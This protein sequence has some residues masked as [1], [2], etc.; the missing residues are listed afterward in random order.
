LAVERAV[1]V[2]PR[3]SGNVSLRVLPFGLLAVASGLRR[4]GFAVRV[5]DLNV[6]P[7]PRLH[8]ALREAP[9]AF[10]GFSV[11]T[12]PMIQQVLALSAAIRRAHPG[13]PLVWGGPHPTIM[14]D[15]TARHPLVDVVCRGEGERTAVLLARA[16]AGGGPLEDVRGLTFKRGGEVVSTPPP[17][18]IPPGEVDREV[19]LDLASVDLAPYVFMNKGKRTAVFITSRGCPY[20]C[21][22][23]WNLMFHGRRYTAW[24]PGKVESE[25]QPLLDAGVEK[26]L[27]FDSFV[28]PVSR[29]RAVGEI[30]RGRGIEWAIEDGCRVDYHGSEE[31]FRTLA[32]TGCTH[33]AFG[34]ESGSQ[35][36]LDLIR[37]DI[38][39]SDILRCA[40]LGREHAIPGRF[41]WM[42][43]IPGETR[44]DALETV[45]LIDEVCRIHDRSGHSMELYLP[46]PG[47]ELFDL[48]RASGWKAP[49]SLEDWGTYRWQGRYPYHP[50]GTWFYK[51]VQYS[52]FFLRYSSLASVSAFSENIKPVF[53]AVR[54]LLRPS[55]SLRWRLR[56]FE[57]PLEY[58]LGES[59][60]GYLE[61]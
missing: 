51:S 18:R 52:N 60:R 59:I 16:L 4:A 21:S 38:A 30:F 26:V 8:E 20:R 3:V 27:I 34:S 24:S 49:E 15:L 25:L 41:Q 42:T 46:Y 22:F 23:C 47:N 54:S 10:V 36:I 55:A 48:A 39:V 2:F 19:S 33:V 57:W 32:E 58:M 12:G 43:G 5:V 13:L 1:L 9:P 56:R 28:G 7:E 45:R 6:E 17:E 31:F 40:R 50:E 44:E 61:R 29:V 53:R 37:K 14:P 35:R 11:F